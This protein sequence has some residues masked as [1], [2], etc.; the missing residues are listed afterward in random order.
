MA[1]IEFVITVQTG[2]GEHDPITDDD[3]IVLEEMLDDMKVVANKS[4]YG[5]E[6]ASW[7]VIE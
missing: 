3:R 2:E 6:L 5:Y 4:D 1:L 7:E